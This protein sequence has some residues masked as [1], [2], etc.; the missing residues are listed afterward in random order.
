MVRLHGWHWC[1]LSSDELPKVFQLSS[2]DLGIS[3]YGNSF[4]KNESQQQA[5][6]QTGSEALLMPSLEILHYQFVYILLV[7]NVTRPA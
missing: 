7:N 4:P 2:G 5:L 1:Q 6:Q 3:Q